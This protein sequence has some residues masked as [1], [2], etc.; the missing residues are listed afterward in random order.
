MTARQATSEYLNRESRSFDR[1]VLEML[2]RMAMECAAWQKL[3]A[4]LMEDRS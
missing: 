2:E 3:A 1:A 4:K